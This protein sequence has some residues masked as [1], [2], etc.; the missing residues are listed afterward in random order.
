[1][2]NVDNNRVIG[3]VTRKATGLTEA[4]D[5]LIKSFDDNIAYLQPA[6]GLM[7]IS[8][9]DHVEALIISQNQMKLASLELERSSN[10]GIGYAYE[11]EHIKD[12]FD[13]L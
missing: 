11:L 8:G 5:E 12:F 4:F 7:R 3:I 10:V 13:H 2:I 6:Q 9:F 1:M